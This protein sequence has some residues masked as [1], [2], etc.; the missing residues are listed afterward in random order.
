[1]G[2]IWLQLLGMIRFLTMHFSSVEIGMTIVV[3]I[4]SVVGIAMF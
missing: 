4:G 1:M 2:L 3:G